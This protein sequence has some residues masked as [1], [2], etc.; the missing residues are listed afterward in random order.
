MQFL[1]RIYVEKKISN[2]NP[3]ICKIYSTVNHCESRFTFTQASSSYNQCIWY[4]TQQCICSKWKWKRRGRS[5]K[6][7]S[8]IDIRHL[9][10]YVSH[11]WNLC[12]FT[13]KLLLNEKNIHIWMKIKLHFI[14]IWLYPRA[15]CFFHLCSNI[16]TQYTINFY[17]ICRKI[18]KKL[19]WGN[20]THKFLYSK[21]FYHHN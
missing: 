6:T 17:F 21:P 11:I 18:P 7:K 1:K 16:T 13:Y 20:K 9:T 10:L 19:K 14:W 4:I 5:N 2:P 15:E 3:N 12:W 8:A